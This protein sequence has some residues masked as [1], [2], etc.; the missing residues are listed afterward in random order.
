MKR[1]DFDFANQLP[2]MNYQQLL[3]A[4]KPIAREAGR[5]VLAIYQGDFEVQTKADESPLT[6]ADRQANEYICG[7]LAA[8]PELFPIISEENR[9]I[10]YAERRQFNYC[11]LV[12]P[13]DGTKEFVSRN[14]DFTINIAL[15][16]RGRAVLGIVYVPIYDELYWAAEGMGAFWENDGVE[17]SIRAANFRL[18]DPGLRVMCSR[19]HL[20]TETEAVLAQFEG[21]ELVS[22]G[23]SL[24]FLLLARGE[25]HVYPRLGP[26]SEWDTGAAQIILEEAGG[27]VIEHE[28]GLPLRYNKESL[29]NPYFMAY[30]AL[31]N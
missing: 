7:Q 13:L 29:L 18:S 15:L 6:L 17:Q 10:P 19:S 20:N 24:K 5:I 30:G 22:R 21:P 31:Q 16:D 1:Q 27:S 25:A 11:W 4:L 23:S 3:Q 12:D 28:T 2:S 14:G 9:E 26:T 8:L